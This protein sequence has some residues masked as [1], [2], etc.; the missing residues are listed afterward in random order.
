M[1]SP[2]ERQAGSTGPP[3]LRALRCAERFDRL[4][5]A[6]LFEQAG[7]P[8]FNVCLHSKGSFRWVQD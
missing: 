3:Q 2:R 8:C 6:A 1:K 5:P 4:E 7:E